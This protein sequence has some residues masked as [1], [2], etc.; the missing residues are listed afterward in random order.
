MPIRAYWHGRCSPLGLGPLETAIM[1][2]LWGA[3]GSLIIREIRDRMDYPPVAYT[4]VATVTNILCGKGLLRR[5]LADRAGHPGPPAWRY[6]AARPASEHIG[7]LIAT[8]LDHSPSPAETLAYA[9][10]TARTGF[11]LD[12]TIHIH[13][14]PIQ[15]HRNDV[16]PAR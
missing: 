9:V 16:R 7:K 13:T 10:S 12:S 6:R 2:V 8:L 5:H 3:D 14:C 15:E 4:T 1:Q 11:Q